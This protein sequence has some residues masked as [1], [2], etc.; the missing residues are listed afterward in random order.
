MQVNAIPWVY[1][2]DGD[3]IAD[4]YYTIILGFKF[5]IQIC[6]TRKIGPKK[7]TTVN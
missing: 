7:C 6:V 3:K 1:G 4:W 5:L 2:Y